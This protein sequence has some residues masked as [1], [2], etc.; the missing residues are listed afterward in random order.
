ME[1]TKVAIGWISDAT[2][3]NVAEKMLI[4]VVEKPKYGLLSG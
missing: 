2:M 1:P 3:Q 4:R